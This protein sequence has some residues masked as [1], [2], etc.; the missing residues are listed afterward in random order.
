MSTQACYI[1]TA[2]TNVPTT[3]E[4]AVL[5]FSIPPYSEPSGQGVYLDANCVMTTGS[6]VTGV[7]VRIRQGTGVTGAVLGQPCLTPAGAST[8]N[9][10]AG[11][12]GL[13]QTPSYPQGNTYTVTVQQ[14]SATGAGTMQQVT[15]SASP[16][17]NSFTG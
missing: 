10:F 16:V 9:T 17:V 5:T 7:T 8:A 4:T 11:C 1:S 3:S 15:V 14:A 12:V 6:A 2:P 13:D